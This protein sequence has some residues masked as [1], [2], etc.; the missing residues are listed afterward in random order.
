MQESLV[1]QQLLEAIASADAV[2]VR[3]LAG[4][5][6]D[7][8][9]SDPGGETPLI[10]AVMGGALET[11]RAVIEA[12]A[13]VNLPQR[14]PRRWT[15]LM[16]AHSSPAIARELITAGA[17]VGARASAYEL[18]SPSAG[19]KT[20][21]GGETALHLAAAANN[22]EVAK[23]LIEAGAQIEAKSENGLAPLDL[24]L[25]AGA[26]N[27]V[28]ELLIKAGA[29]L[30]PDRLELAHAASHEP[31]SDLWR[32]P[33]STE[34]DPNSDSPV[35]SPGASSEIAPAAVAS[36]EAGPAYGELRCPQCR[37][38]IYSRRPK[39]CGQCGAT[40]PPE[41]TLTDEQARA[42]RE[43]R[44]WAREM[45]D[46]F[47]PH[48]SGAAQRHEPGAKTA[49]A[50]QT[51]ALRPRPSDLI[52]AVSSAEAFRRR[53]RP[54]FWVYVAAYLVVACGLALLA[55]RLGGLP[56][57]AILPAGGL[58]ALFCL[59]AWR[60]ASPICPSCKQ[61]IR[62]CV[63]SCCHVCGRPLAGRA[64]QH[65]AVDHSVLGLFLPYASAGNSRSIIHCPGCGVYLDSRVRRWR[66]GSRL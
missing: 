39:V 21:H 60:R 66:P 53:D 25:S 63:A 11:V 29:T 34:R 41:L 62:T 4:A 33:S 51:E 23:L 14:G 42:A 52:R 35:A 8:H 47:G 31:D 44:R 59:A 16:F 3:E 49:S 22:P 26:P 50:G 40:L 19:A 9:T 45:A 28:A 24:A 15:P 1:Q 46:Q 6:M 64:C 27:Q 20:R 48:A 2:R 36:S 10:R 55:Q 58:L 54:D 32:F 57:L 5:A 43:A 37:S 12:G 65:C 56:P 61:N 17:D 7:A 30:T 13:D 18:I 38:L